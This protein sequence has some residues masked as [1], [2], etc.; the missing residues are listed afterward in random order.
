LDRGYI[1][2]YTTSPTQSN[3]QKGIHLHRFAGSADIHIMHRLRVAI[4]DTKK[5]PTI[6]PAELT[7][8]LTAL[9]K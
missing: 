3:C 8:A 2:I 6:N 1:A 5:R 7:K 9:S 4:L